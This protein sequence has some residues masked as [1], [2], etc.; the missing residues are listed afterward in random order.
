MRASRKGRSRGQVLVIF[1]LSIVTFIGLMAVVIDVAWYWS[2]SLR[3]Q[4]ASDAA[5]LAGVVYLPGDEPSAIAKAK[6]EASK[7]GFTDGT[8]GTMVTAGKDPN[9]PRN[10]R[11]TISASFPTFFMRLFGMNTLN[12]SAASEA[13]YVLP[14]PMG[15]PDNYY[16]VFG[17]LRTPA[18]GTTLSNTVAE[19]TTLLPPTTYPSGNWTNPKNAL[20][21]ADGG[22]SAT[23][24][25]TSS[26]NQVWAG[27]NVPVPSSGTFS[28]TGIEVDVRAM[29]SLAANCQLGVA[30]TWNG[31]TWTSVAHTLTVN[32]TSQAL[33]TTGGAGDLWGKSAATWSTASALSNANFRVQL[34]YKAVTGCA[35][36]WLA[37]VDAIS[38]RLFW[39]HT[40]T[41]FIPDQNITGPG[42]EALNPRGFWGEMNSEGAESVNGDAYLTYY[43]TRTSSVNAAYDATQYY[44]YAVYMPAGSANGTVWIYDPVF[45]ATNTSG[46]YGT[47]DRWFSGTAAVSAFY[48]VYDTKET[49]YDLTDDSLVASS[50]NLFRNIQASDPTLNGPS[51]V[52]SC[53]QGAVTD[54]ADG[55]YWH[56]R[57]WQLASGL[58][59]GA[60]GKTY[61]VQTSSTD[62]SSSA[63]QLGADAQ[64]SFAIFV[65]A[66]GG[67]PSVYGN[68]AMQAYSPLDPGAT[69]EFYLAQIDAV[70]AGKTVVINL[71]DPGDTGALSASL[72]I[73]IP[74][75]T[76]YTPA[77]LTWK[78]T[79]G[80]TGTTSCGSGSGTSIVTNT[81]NNSKFNGC[82]VVISIPIPTSYTAPAPPGE[83]Q[84]GWWK[85]RY[86]M[87]TQSA[88]PAFDVTTWTVQIRG[89]PVHL[90]LP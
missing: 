73:L 88:T 29:S 6:A 79:K 18:G 31:S 23:K 1:A 52:S 59:G 16:G 10:L 35:S 90:I 33:Y 28:V 56:N 42:G 54:P 75:D 58:D 39:D 15:S 62:P 36:G 37:S 49:P 34:T 4:R 85:I 25:S 87:G 89:N 20:T 77:N 40:T 63:A 7:N 80:T 71:W 47:G 9:L 22:A 19:S 8:G 41:T 50:G 83:A 64:N 69:S 27:F 72:Q 74:T 55:R 14:V 38:V 84:P 43:N 86:V 51:G 45:C 17:E 13:E 32:S 44:N 30:L 68:G 46:Q 82:W 26:P 81:G 70:H 60:T 65:S 2:N 48:N 11:V 78:A 12:A 24:N 76:G 67:T 3:L 66:S 53:A 21:D 57:W 5:A 61:R